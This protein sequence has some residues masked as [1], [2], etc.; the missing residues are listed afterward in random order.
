MKQ[1][2]CRMK[3]R[4]EGRKWI[5]QIAL[6]SDI[7]LTCEEVA[8]ELSIM[9][10]TALALLY[11]LTLEGYFRLITTDNITATRYFAP[12]KDRI[13]KSVDLIIKEM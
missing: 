9:Y 5:L 2:P 12:N 3:S 6:K 10:P 4:A 1:K 13:L 7:P 11:D 8:E